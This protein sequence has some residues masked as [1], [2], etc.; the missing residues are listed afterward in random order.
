MEASETKALRKR[1]PS[2]ELLPITPPN[3]AEE[4]PTKTIRRRCTPEVTVTA[5]PQASTRIPI[6]GSVFLA[7]DGLPSATPDAS[8]F[9]SFSSER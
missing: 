4:R 5:T 2:K 3:D 1:R 9:R 8:D 7:E 6:D